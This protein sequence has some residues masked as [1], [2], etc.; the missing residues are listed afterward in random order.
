MTDCFLQEVVFEVC[1]RQ[2]RAQARA[3]PWAL[4]QTW[5]HMGPRGARAG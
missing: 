2:P 5:A 4:G 1:D 3:R